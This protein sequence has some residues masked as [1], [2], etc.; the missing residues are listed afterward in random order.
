MQSQSQQSSR[1]IVIF[2][3]GQGE[4]VSVSVLCKCVSALVCL[5]E[6]EKSDIKAH[7]GV[8]ISSHI[9]VYTMLSRTK[10]LLGK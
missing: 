10:V 7:R 1:A 4:S 8:Y 9:C 3:G 6:S 5:D 2:T